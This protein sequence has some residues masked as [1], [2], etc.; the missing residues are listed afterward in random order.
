MQSNGDAEANRDAMRPTPRGLPISHDYRYRMNPELIEVLSR[1]GVRDLN[2]S[3]AWA[4]ILLVNNHGRVP[5]AAGPYAKGF[6]LVVLDRN[7]RPHWF[8]RCSWADADSIRREVEI[9]NAIQTSSAAAAVPESLFLST[10]RISVLLT[11]YVGRGTYQMRLNR[12]SPPEWL[13]DVEDILVT[14]ETLMT[15]AALHS[16]LARQRANESARRTDM[17]STMHTL[18]AAG[19]SAGTSQLLETVLRQS[20]TLPYVLQHGDLW[21]AN[22][23]CSKT[24]WWLIDFAEC[25]R[26]WLPAFDLF[27]MLFSGPA[28]ANENWFACGPFLRITDWT[29]ARLEIARWYARRHSLTKRDMGIAL[30]SYLSHLAAR[31]M[32]PGAPRTFVDPLLAQLERICA[33]MR[34]ASLDDIFQYDELPVA[35]RLPHTAT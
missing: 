4:R 15:S 8:A 31:R 3:D 34:N 29:A 9:V 10:P 14:S 13:R 1:A 24:K 21:P 11:R 5:N 23:I 20:L 7:N 26:L 16:S 30:I 25:G 17:A 2:H 19:V 12:L 33:F 32:V 6:K 27:H 28:I 22:V 35:I 18:R